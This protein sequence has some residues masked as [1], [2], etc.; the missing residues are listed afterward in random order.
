MA[1]KPSSQL[2]AAPTSLGIGSFTYHYMHAEA[3]CCSSDAAIPARARDNSWPVHCQ[4]DGS[5]GSCC[6]HLALGSRYDSGAGRSP[7]S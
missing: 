2:S 3:V 7:R 5:D 6:I 4:E 1:R